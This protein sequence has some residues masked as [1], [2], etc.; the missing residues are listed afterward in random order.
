[1]ALAAAAAAAGL[2]CQG[3]V[4]A[5]APPTN[6]TVSL[7]GD[8]QPIFDAR[9]TSCHSPGF[10]TNTIV[11][12]PMV[13]TPGRSFGSLVNQASAQRP[14]LTL[15]TPGEP[16]ASLLWL[17]VSSNSPP[18]GATMPLIGDR[19][20]SAELALVRDWIAQGARNN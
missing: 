5:P 8:I 6:R 10:P 12:I 3:D 16:D 18:V 11:G 17:K 7:A 15:V 4:N 20:S 9:C 13:L 1:M 14:D 2:A 19:L